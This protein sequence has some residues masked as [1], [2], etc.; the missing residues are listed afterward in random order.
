MENHNLMNGRNLD[1]T[2]LIREVL[3]DYNDNPEKPHRATG[4]TPKEATKPHNDFEVRTNLI[5]HSR[6]DREYP[7]LKKNDKVQV[8][9]KKKLGDKQ[10]VSV[11]DE[12]ARP[13]YSIKQNRGQHFY[14]LSKEGHWLIRARV[15]RLHDSQQGQPVR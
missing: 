6:R 7:E 13:V 4:M 8:F 10:W 12:H 2:S 5:I 3:E 14:R 9:K 11:W 15:H 1:W